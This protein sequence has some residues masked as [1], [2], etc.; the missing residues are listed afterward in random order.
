MPFNPSYLKLHEAG[1][2]QQRLEQIE[3]LTRGC[4][5]C[6]REC[7]VDRAV[8]KE[9]L[10]GSG[11]PPVA[12]SFCPHFGEEPPLVGR[13]GSGTIF[14]TGCNLKCVF[15]QNHDIS[16]LRC[17]EEISYQDLAVMMISLQ[18]QGCHNI[19]FV[20]PTHMAYAV[21]KSLIIA[22]DMGLRLPLVYNTG[23]YDSVETLR[24]LDGIIDLYMPDI[25]Y[26][27]A[28]AAEELSGAKDYPPVAQQAVREMHRQAGDL[29][30]SGGIARRGLIVRHLVLPENLAGTDEVVK[31]VAGL[32]RQT[33][34][35]LMDQYR[36]EHRAGGYP[37]LARR[38]TH[39]EFAR[40]V[41]MAG[42]EGLSGKAY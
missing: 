29:E 5:L 4:R 7:G 16:Q 21:I 42:R 23:G 14:F 10:C 18:N 12:S 26:S 1:L 40:A 37:G 33:Y 22:I 19:N 15:C 35:N 20:T 25:K 36:P 3:E 6:P 8:S 28:A 30:T 31:F 34:L 13:H 9:G 32:S 2:L 24:L 11:L 41:D 27:N 38:L 39:E 17:G